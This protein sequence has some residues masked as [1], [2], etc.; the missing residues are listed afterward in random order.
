MTTHMTPARFI[1]ERVFGCRSQA[2]FAER[3]GYSQ[4]QVCRMETDRLSRDAMDRI[5]NIAIG[6]GMQWDDTWFFEVPD[7]ATTQQTDARG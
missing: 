7:V 4:A 3:L 6:S 5:R 2:E 1:R